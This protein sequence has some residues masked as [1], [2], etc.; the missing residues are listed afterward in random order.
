MA[1]ADGEAEVID[2]DNL[3]EALAD[4][5]DLDHAPRHPFST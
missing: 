5:V 1:G 3:A 2:R 4:V